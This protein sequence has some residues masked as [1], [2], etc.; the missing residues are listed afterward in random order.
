MSRPVRAA[1]ALE[2]SGGASTEED[3]AAIVRIAAALRALIPDL[4]LWNDEARL[5]AA[6]S[7]TFATKARSALV[8]RPATTEEVAAILRYADGERV[9]VYP[10]SRG[11]NFGFG[12][13]VPA[14]SVVILLDLSRMDRILEYDHG[15]GTLRVEPGVTFRRA[16]AFLSEQ[17]DRYFLNAIGG[18][19]EA[20]LIGNALERGDGA[21]PYCERAS[22][23]CDFEVVL[24]DG[25]IVRTGFGKWEDS[26][27]GP[28][29]RHGA[30][31]GMDDLFLQSNLGVVTGMT[32]WLQRRPATFRL[33]QFQLRESAAL[34][35]A[36]EAFRDLLK[37]NVVAGPIVLWN[38]YKL[39]ASG[40]QY[41]WKLDGDVVP[42]RRERLRS[43]SNAYRAWIGHGGVY[44]DDESMSAAAARAVRRT[45]RR[46]LG[47]SGTVSSLSSRRIRWLSLL[48]RLPWRRLD[49]RPLIAQWHSSPALGSVSNFGART[50]YW[51][52]RRPPPDEPD[53]VADRCGVLSN[54]FEL[55]LEGAV[56]AEFIGRLEA[57]L[58]RHGYE[59]ML[60][61]TLIN[62]RYAKCFQQLMY[63][64]EIAGED[65]KA[66]ACHVELFALIEDSG[67]T[68]SRVDILHMEDMRR[69]ARSTALRDRIAR[70][71]D[72]N[73][74]LA[75]G[76]YEF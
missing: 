34:A 15:H 21:G 1:P 16:A 64:R 46:S 57:T 45:L 9:A 42:L 36:I 66:R 8:A 27:L 14:R 3:E 28:L 24:A 73:G 25:T 6:N 22:F 23:V 37:R 69:R 39:M 43:I 38:D 53:P 63:D 76:R 54:C 56:I 51:R 62:D 5:E 50:M 29:S 47:R 75:P 4:E 12:S 13:R 11:C 67:F 20:S 58:L 60:S 18:P 19:P 2:R 74:I 40:T 52:K 68:H 70:S 41:P 32:F 31:P 48:S 49:H 72:P 17:G 65:A 26:R 30:G 55:P 44:I 10:V 33:Y 71:L 7:A 35:P 61:L 59:P